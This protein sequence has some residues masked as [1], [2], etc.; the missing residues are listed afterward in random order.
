MSL[1]LEQKKAV[2]A[3]LA[4][5]LKGA[6][7]AML[8]E[9]RGLSVEQMTKLRRKARQDKVYLRVI[10]NTLA[11]RAVDGSDWACLQDQ[12]SGPLAYAVSSDPVAVA[13][14]LSEFAKD[15]DALKIKA[16]AM[17]GKLMTVAQIQALATLPGREQL[18]AM[19]LGTMQAPVQ[20]FVQT[21][22][23][24]PAKFVRT[25]AAVRDAKEKAA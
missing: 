2:V 10:K 4:E 7:A 18:L 20:K 22:N 21:L 11:R 17:G 6:Q 13:K 12:M 19:L 15:N 3:E 16:G 14:V 23:E 25:L 1:N 9:Y 24:V 5:Q 8:A